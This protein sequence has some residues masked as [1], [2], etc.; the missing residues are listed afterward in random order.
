MRDQRE[1][2]GDHVTGGLTLRLAEDQAVE[3]DLLGLAHSFLIEEEERLALDDG[4]ANVCAELV[5]FERQ[6]VAG[7]QAERI[8]GVQLVVTQ[9]LKHLTVECAAARTRR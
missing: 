8:P 1:Q 7:R 9:E 4:S 6:R 3:V 2:L 5:A